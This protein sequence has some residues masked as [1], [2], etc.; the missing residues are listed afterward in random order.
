M[1]DQRV[2]RWGQWS[3]FIMLFNAPSSDGRIVRFADGRFPW[4]R[5][6]VPLRM[7]VREAQGDD[8]IPTCVGTV[9][10]LSLG[11]PSSLIRDVDNWALHASGWVDLNAVEAGDPSASVW[12]PLE[13]GELVSA[14]VAIEGADLGKTAQDDFMTFTG[15]WRLADVMLGSSKVWPYTGIQLDSVHY[16]DTAEHMPPEWNRS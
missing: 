7:N 11:Q 16:R 14:C 9:E 12:D 10:E 8:G 5:L 4:A 6:P 1:P 2:S 3:G 13:E 15:N